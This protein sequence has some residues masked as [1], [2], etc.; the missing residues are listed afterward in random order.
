MFAHLSQA[1]RSKR[2]FALGMTLLLLLSSL[3]AAAQ[4]AT[5]QVVAPES[6]DIFIEKW[7]CPPDV[8]LD[9]SL[10]T[11]LQL[12]AP[13]Y[14]PFGFA[15][16]SEA[17]TSRKATRGGM[18]AWQDVPSGQ[19]RITERV[20]PGYNTTFI[21]C[22][23]ITQVEIPIARSPGIFDPRPYGPKGGISPIGV[24]ET[25]V[26]EVDILWCLWFNVLSDG[27]TR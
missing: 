12:C 5:A 3:G 26:V 27:E 4:T 20:P 1:R 25:H 24:F 13:S 17:G 15:L 14:E 19:I 18:V 8:P 6:F 11:L 23:Q 10:D 16:Q 2:L 22:S 21:S 7:V 9:G